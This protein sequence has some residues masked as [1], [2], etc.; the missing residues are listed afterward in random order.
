[1]RTAASPEF[2]R[3]IGILRKQCPT[4]YPVVVQ[5]THR[6]RRHTEPLHGY[7]I[8]GRR[9]GRWV[10]RV[11]V[12]RASMELMVETLIHEWAHA[13]AEEHRHSDRWARAYGRCY[14]A[15]FE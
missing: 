9:R 3:T 14:R 2:Y 6:L 4:R 15:V 10:Y 1:M 13:L 7:F 11:M 8:V 5:T 12:N